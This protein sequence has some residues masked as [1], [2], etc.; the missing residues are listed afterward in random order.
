MAPEQIKHLI[1]AGLPGA[2]VDVTGDGAHFE[3]IVVSEVFRGKGALE[4]HR[5]VYSTLGDRMG[6]GVI[7]ALS[8]R[9]FT[10]E[11]WQN[12]RA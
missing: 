8:I 5:L 11:E 7:H 9:A 2:Q 12:R 3:A 6:T 10:P 1:E 4:K